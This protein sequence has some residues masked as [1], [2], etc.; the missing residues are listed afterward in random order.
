MME[1]YVHTPLHIIVGYLLK[2]LA[3]LKSGLVKILY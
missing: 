3:K 2:E 1:N